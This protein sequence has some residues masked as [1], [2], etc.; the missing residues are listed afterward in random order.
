MLF[1]KA[2]HAP[3]VSTRSLEVPGRAREASAI[4]TGVLVLLPV[5]RYA[6]PIDGRVGAALVASV[7]V[8]GMGARGDHTRLRRTDLSFFLALFV[9]PAIGLAL[10][11]FSSSLVETVGLSLLT[12]MLGFASLRPGNGESYV[13]GCWIALMA[14][15]TLS[16]LVLPSSDAWTAGALRGVFSNPNG[17]GLSALLA[18][19]IGGTEPVRQRIGPHPLLVGRLVA[20]AVIPFTQSR[21]A[22]VG[23]LAALTWG[24]WR[25]WSGRRA[26]AML[27]GGVMS[28][29]YLV[30]G[31]QGLVVRDENDVDYI[32]ALVAEARRSRADFWG[33][34][35][36]EVTVLGR[37]LGQAA[38][39]FIG[40]S[41]VHV[42]FSLGLAGIVLA[43]I[44]TLL[45][46]RMALLAEPGHA[47]LAFGGLV[48][49]LFES[50]LFAVGTAYFLIY[51]MALG[52]RRFSSRPRSDLA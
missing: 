43:A 23:L 35:V 34:R 32:H 28:I 8:L 13:V 15:T 20:L 6:A 10:G 5:T 36:E 44:V 38:E 27:G 22:L 46:V 25:R 50:W 45:L 40:N 3:L 1:T 41:W 24:P 39:G 19:L 26:L 47:R 30:Y 4:A 29:A 21:G 51:W 16:L 9:L 11:L 31:P 14:A 37:G 18:V 12:L 52:G 2:P 17:L 33:E 49:G 48:A 42:A 7:V